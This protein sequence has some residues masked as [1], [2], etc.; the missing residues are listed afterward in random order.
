MNDSFDLQHFYY[1]KLFPE[2]HDPSGFT[3]IARVRELTPEQ[4]LRHQR[5]VQPGS[6][7]GMGVKKLHFGLSFLQYDDQTFLASAYYPA[8]R[9][10]R[11]V[12]PD[13][14]CVIVPAAIVYAMGSL[15]LLEALA[16]HF[17]R[18]LEERRVFQK[19]T[20][21]APLR[22]EVPQECQL[23]TYHSALDLL[24]G[25]DADLIG[26][27]LSIVL[28]ER[29]V[30][31]IDIPE[32]AT[33]GNQPLD[34]V[35]GLTALLPPQMQYILTFATDVFDASSFRSARLKMAY[36]DPLVK[37]NESDITL[38]WGSGMPRR[39]I[40]ETYAMLLEHTWRQDLAQAASIVHEVTDRLNR[41]PDL[42]A[43]PQGAVEIASQTIQTL[44]SIEYG[45]ASAG[46]ILDILV[47]D[48]TLMSEEQN[49]LI[50]YAMQLAP[51][52]IAAIAETLLDTLDYRPHLVRLA[53][54]TSPIVK[55]YLCTLSVAQLKERL[56]GWE[57]LL[58]EGDE[59]LCIALGAMQ[60]GYLLQERPRSFDNQSL[61]RLA[62][63]CLQSSPDPLALEFL[64]KA[65][66]AQQ[67]D[68]DLAR[69]IADT[70]FQ[71]GIDLNWKDSL[72]AN[73]MGRL[74]LFG[75]KE[76]DEGAVLGLLQLAQQPDIEKGILGEALNWIL[77]SSNNQE[78]I[79]LLQRLVT[80]MQTKDKQDATRAK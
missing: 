33:L 13:Y 79:R 19:E 17:E 44:N 11:G 52:E 72:L 24:P 16:P 67:A 21:L 49:R 9:K 80:V 40:T 46:H 54:A 43:N 66:P 5:F 2:A 22:L 57:Y 75:W 31:V 61:F 42:L 10:D 51:K 32:E 77:E 56:V 64:E 41:A 25:V 38:V 71:W 68:T 76:L 70:V 63:I 1:G 6:Y 45:T 26:S 15:R 48:T 3:I 30:Q 29:F 20:L 74:Y 47:Q 7:A 59:S 12:H 78:R 62:H 65:S 8:S 18:D 28:E 69:N 14:H 60:L 23:E 35:K 53:E 4:A 36:P 50:Q 34:F 39:Q 27:L 37:K 58:A 73:A 55:Q